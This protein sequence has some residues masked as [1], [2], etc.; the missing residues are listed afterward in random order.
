MKRLLLLLAACGTDEVDLTGLYRV[1]S[2]VASTGTCM[3]EQ[4]VANPP[5]ALKF[6]QGSLFGAEYFYYEECEDLTGSNCAGSGLFGNSFAE[7]IDGGWRGVI[8]ATSGIAPNCTISF[9]E[10]TAT[11]HGNVIIVESSTHGAGVTTEAECSTDE[12]EKRN[13]AMPCTGHERIEATEL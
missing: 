11:L 5:V 12:A 2:D 10:Q 4:A 3:N 13:T 1:D 9:T 8:T 6:A 7:P